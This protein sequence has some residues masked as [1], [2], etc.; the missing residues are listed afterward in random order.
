M[1]PQFKFMQSAFPLYFLKEIARQELFRKSWTAG[2]CRLCCLWFLLVE[3]V[4]LLLFCPAWR[5]GTE[6][7]DYT[8]NWEKFK[9]IPKN[10]LSYVSRSSPVIFQTGIFSTSRHC[11]QM[12]LLCNSVVNQAS[13][14][15]C[16]EDRKTHVPEKCCGLCHRTP[17]K[18]ILQSFELF[19]SMI[20]VCAMILLVCWYIFIFHRTLSL[21][22]ALV[23]PSGG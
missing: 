16:E 20:C 3:T 13:L 19:L 22:D 2:S 7:G 1:K 8:F 4:S 10:T 15:R 14:L 5:C 21:A 9:F 11:V 17:F 18:L 23:K 6:F 12:N